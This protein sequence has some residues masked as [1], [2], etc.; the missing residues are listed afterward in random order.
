MVAGKEGAAAAKAG[1]DLIGDQ[2]DA[3]GIAKQTHLAQILG[4]IKTHAA[5][6]LDNG[7]EDH[8]AQLLMVLLDQSRST[9]RSC[10]R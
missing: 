1:G 2:Q 9:I 10:A 8:R 4:M 7:F 3:K 5:R 6:T